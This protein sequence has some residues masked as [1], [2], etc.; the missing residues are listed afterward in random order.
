MANQFSSP[1]TGPW[2]FLPSSTRC[3][4]DPASQGLQIVS[5]STTNFAAL[6][7]SVKIPSSD[8]HDV[9]TSAALLCRR[10]SFPTEN[11]MRVPNEL[12]DVHEFIDLPHGRCHFR[13][14]GPDGGQPVLL[15]H[16]ATVPGWEFDRIAPQLAA[17]GFRLVCPDLFGHGYSDRPRRAFDH[18]LFVRQSADLLDALGIR[19]PVH[20]FG[21]S[22]GAAIATRLALKRPEKIAA[23][24]LG[25]PLLDFTGEH[26]ATRILEPWPLGECLM[27]TY[28]IPMLIRRRERRY[29]GIEDG[30]FA[31]MYRDQFLIPGFGRAFLSLLRSGGLGDQSD[32]YARLEQLEHPVLMMRGTEDPIF[33]EA[34]F[35]ALQRLLPRAE[36]AEVGE[37]G[38]PMIL[39]HPGRVAPHVTDFLSKANNPTVRRF[40]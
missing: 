31:R 12:P 18:A 37:A 27:P 33:T 23:L 4:G 29:R 9:E 8:R 40:R 19:S 11:S 17:E 20:L 25:A 14:F 39:T 34:Q 28:V 24:V 10:T 6:W 36:V 15:L 1:K 26:A 38:H 16:G 2:I 13:T 5:R 7:R 3:P 22:L 35:A 30:R 21:H 32:C